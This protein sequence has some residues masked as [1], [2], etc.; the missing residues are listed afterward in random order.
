MTKVMPPTHTPAGKFAKG[1][2]G[3]PGRRPGTQVELRIQYMTQLVETVPIDRWR[4]VCEK[5]IIQAEEG[6][7]RA[8]LFLA[9]Y[10]IGR[11][12]TQVEISGPGGTEL[13][14]YKVINVIAAQF[15]DVPGAAEK[16]AMALGQLNAPAIDVTTPVGD[17]PHD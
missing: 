11:P 16:I 15:G 4:K 10:L 1:Y 5:A 7:A 9:N 3:G 14:L 17:A 2:K 12:V 6:D 13:N 8:R